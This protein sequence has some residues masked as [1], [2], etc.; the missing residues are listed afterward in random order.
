MPK[1]FRSLTQTESVRQAQKHYYGAYEH[2]V[3]A[4]MSDE[5]SP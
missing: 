5:L 1:H 4:A 3:P 2:I